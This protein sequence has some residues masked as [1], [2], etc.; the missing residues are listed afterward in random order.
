MLTVV[1]CFQCNFPFWESNASSYI[2]HHQPDPAEESCPEKDTFCLDSNTIVFDSENNIN[3]SH[4]AIDR[5]TELDSSFFSQADSSGKE[6]ENIPCILELENLSSLPS[7][8]EVDDDF[9]DSLLSEIEASNRDEILTTPSLPSLA[10]ETPAESNL[11]ASVNPV[12][13]I[14]DSNTHEASGPCSGLQKTNSRTDVSAAL[15]MNDCN[16]NKASSACVSSNA[17]RT[18]CFNNINVDTALSCKNKL[19]VCPQSS[20]LPQYNYLLWKNEKNLCWLDVLLHCLTNSTC[21]RAALN[22]NAGF[23]AANS[24]IHK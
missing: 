1:T 15:G 7:I 20:F 17:V 3:K 13:D 24:V 9:L 10:V 11:D 23:Q 5:K 18:N 2:V 8:D 16:V 22:Y 6:L 21:I 19:P 12:V 14:T 4:P